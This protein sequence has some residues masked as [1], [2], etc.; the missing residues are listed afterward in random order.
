[1]E[2][3]HARCA[4][5]DVHQ[6]QLAACVRI[7][8]GGKVRREVRSFETTT[9]GLWALSEWLSAEGCTHV[10]MESTGV[11]WK[12]VWHVLESSFELVLANAA[13]IRNVPGRKSDLSDARWIADLLAHG[14][15]RGS[16]VPPTPSRSCAT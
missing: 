5:L 7:V 15:I 11:Y 2:V 16:F 13:H 3:V 1:M 8:E 10:A 9:A 4:R 12:P 14:L 6:Q